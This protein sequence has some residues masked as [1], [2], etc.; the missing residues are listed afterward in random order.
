MISKEERERI[1]REKQAQRKETKEASQANA[2]GRP[3]IGIAK[4]DS[5]IA[6]IKNPN[7]S[8]GDDNA[9]LLSSLLDAVISVV[10][11]ILSARELGAVATTCHV[12][13]VALEECRVMH[14]WER[15]KGCC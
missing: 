11:T 9:S 10:L 15:V 6:G 8:N 7:N 13:N 3:K 12:L 14:L 4:T 5:Y 1:R 2:A